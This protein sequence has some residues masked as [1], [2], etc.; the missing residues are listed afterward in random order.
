V[1]AAM[2]TAIFAALTGNT[3]LTAVI[4]HDTAT[5]GPAIYYDHR[6][7]KS[8]QDLYPVI[9]FRECLLSPHPGM[10]MSGEVGYGAIDDEFYDFTIEDSSERTREA[11]AIATIFEIMDPILNLQQLV[12][13]TPTKNYN[14]R[15][16]R[17]AGGSPGIYDKNLKTWIGI[18]R[19]KMVCAHA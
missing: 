12:L 6:N 8:A 5:N 10:E 11:N 7:E 15:C 14:Y 2:T 9:V 17:I 4:G 13:A 3:A 1:S 18:Y 19:Y 16:L